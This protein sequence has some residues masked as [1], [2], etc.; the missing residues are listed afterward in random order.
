MKSLKIFTFLAFIL[1]VNVGFSQKNQ[2]RAEEL[3]DEI[4]DKTDQNYNWNNLNFKIKNE[5]Y[6]VERMYDDAYAY[7]T[8]FRS[9]NDAELNKINQEIDNY[10]AKY[11]DGKN[12]K[13]LKLIYK[14]EGTGNEIFGEK[15]NREVI[16]QSELEPRCMVSIMETL[17]KPKMKT[18][19]D[20][21]VKGKTFRL[22]KDRD[23]EKDGFLV[24]CDNPL[25]NELSKIFNLIGFSNPY[26]AF[27]F[28]KYNNRY[29]YDFKEKSPSE[30]MISFQPAKDNADFN[31]YLKVNTRDQAITELHINSVENANLDQFKAGL[32][33][34]KFIVTNYNLDLIFKNVKGI[35]IPEKI[36]E[37]KKVDVQKE[38]RTRK[39]KEN[40]DQNSEKLVFKYNDARIMTTEKTFEFEIVD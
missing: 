33:G 34:I 5:H 6:Q 18:K 39:F 23:L 16:D 40:T 37:Y 26:D 17:L 21:T 25:K 32:L 36:K 35:Y 9:K 10:L 22:D 12:K 24:C 1:F 3:F 29:T 20:Y 28:F 15:K 8:K 2:D 7:V 13:H 38:K 31:G 30:L 4:I 14:G 19:N 27:D 11:K